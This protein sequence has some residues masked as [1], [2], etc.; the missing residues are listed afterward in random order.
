[1]SY[2]ELERLSFNQL[3]ERYDSSRD[4]SEK[5]GLKINNHLHRIQIFNP[6]PKQMILNYKIF[7]SRKKN[8]IQINCFWTV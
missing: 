8:S 1:M 7:Y 6:I 4:E 5:I 2:S 3:Y